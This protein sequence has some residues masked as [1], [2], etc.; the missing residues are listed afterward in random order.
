MNVLLTAANGRTGRMV[1]AA[2]K[3]AGAEVKVFIRDAGQWP[4]LQALGAKSYALGDMED[5][6][7]IDGAVAGCERI[8]HIGPPMH[9]H[10]VEI[11]SR[12]IDAARRHGLG[13]FIYYSV[14]HPLLRDIRHHRLKLDTEQ[15]LVDSGLVFTIV[16]PSRYMQHLENIWKQLLETGVHGMPFSVSQQFSVVD[17]R[18]LAEATAMVTTSPGHE[19][20]CYELAG[21]ELLSQTDMAATISKL[22]GREIRAEAV[23]LDTMAEKA[24]AKGASDDRVAQMMAMNAHYDAHG[25]RGNPNVLS[26][27]LGRPPA[28]FEDY[29]GRLIEQG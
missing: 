29:V 6:D 10:E 14:M 11:T 20:A 1:L 23:S 4:E 17:L 8:V 13:R 21:P 24:R 3:D 9:P 16:Q 26:W 7:S 25:F 18:D 28:T 27:L 2:L 5:P 22:L 12:F 19:Y 15:V